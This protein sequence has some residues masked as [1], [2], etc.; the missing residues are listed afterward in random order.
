MVHG[1]VEFRARKVA[2]RVLPPGGEQHREGVPSPEIVVGQGVVDRPRGC[3]HER[4]KHQPASQQKGQVVNVGMMAPPPPP[5]GHSEYEGRSATE[6]CQPSEK[7]DPSILF[8]SVPRC[9]LPQLDH[10]DGREEND[11]EG[12]RGGSPDSRVPATSAL[13][14]SLA[15]KSA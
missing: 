7:V 15:A 11:E 12:T 4:Q 9:R 5:A 2:H 8:G 14:D 6:D 3:S 13:P 1:I 10:D